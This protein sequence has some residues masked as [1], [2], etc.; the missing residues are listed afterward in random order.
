[1]TSDDLQPRIV[2]NSGAF[3]L[4][5]MPVGGWVSVVTDDNL[6]AAHL[7]RFPKTAL[8]Y[9]QFSADLPPKRETQDGYKTQKGS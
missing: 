5:I 6:G 1:M 3:A 8:V 2:G 4:E 9:C 7:H